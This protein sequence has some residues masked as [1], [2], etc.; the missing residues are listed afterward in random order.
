MY[1]AI[2]DISSVAV[3][4][5]GLDKRNEWAKEWQLSIAI[6]CYYYYLFQ[7]T[8]IHR[9]NEKYEQIE[10]IANYK[11]SVLHIGDNN[12]GHS[13]FSRLHFFTQLKRNGATVKDMVHFY[14]TVIRSVLKYVCPA[15]HSS[16]T[17]EQCFRIE[18]IQRRSFK[19]IYCSTSHYENIYHVY[20]HM[21]LYDRREL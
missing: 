11:C 8:Q 12:P 16:L 5:S 1:T 4:Q 13:C 3:L 19:L 6:I 2:R 14:E 10:Q 18:S 21:S 17:V 9:I 7:T 20:S 15:W